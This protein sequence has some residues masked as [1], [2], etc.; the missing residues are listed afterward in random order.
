MVGSIACN[1]ERIRQLY[2]RIEETFREKPHSPEHLAA[3][4]QFHNEYDSLAFP[5]GLK[6]AL[7]RLKRPDKKLVETAVQFLE[8]DPRFFRSGY[9]K[10]TLLRRL[11]HCP[12]TEQQQLRVSRLIIRSMDAGGRKEFQGYSRLARTI[13]PPK[14]LDAVALRLQ[15]SNPEQ[16]RRAKAVQHI[17]DSN[18]LPRTS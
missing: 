14:L 8:A 11:K 15:S 13:H 10:E 16:V 9:I 1:A 6:A 12:L 4:E 17:L 5:G 7:E 3:C 18:H 2:E